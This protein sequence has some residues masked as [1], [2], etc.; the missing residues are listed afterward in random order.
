MPLRGLLQALENL[1]HSEGLAHPVR[2]P[3]APIYVPLF[4]ND[5]KA[6]HHLPN[7]AWGRGSHSFRVPAPL[8]NPDSRQR[9]SGQQVL[10][11]KFYRIR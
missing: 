2:L 11:G 8:V 7:L 4:L 5:L 3:R 1:M 9:T 6:F 10:L